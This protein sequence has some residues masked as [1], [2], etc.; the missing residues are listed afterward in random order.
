MNIS[1]GSGSN[2]SPATGM[3]IAIRPLLVRRAFIYG[4]MDKIFSKMFP[5][6]S[7]V[8]ALAAVLAMV[9][10]SPAR[11]QTPRLDAAR[12]AGGFTAPLYVTAPPGDTSRIFVVQQTGQILIINL[13]SRTVNAIPYLD[14]SGEIVYGGEQGLLGMAFDPNYA[15][16]GR[17]YLNYTAPGGSFGAG[18]S[19]IAEF[20]VSSDPDIADPGSEATLLTFDQ[21]QTNHNGGWVGFSSRPGDE[22]N[23]YI[24]TGD[25]GSANDAGEG[26]IEP[27]GNAQN[28]TTLLGKMLRIHIEDAPGTYSIPLDNPFYG[29]DTAKQEIFC[30][31]L[32]N[33]F[34]NSFDRVTGAML[35]G[36]VGQS[37][38]EEID[39]QKVS[40]P[41]GGEN[42]GWRVREGFIQNPAYPNDPPPPDAVDPIFDYPHTTGQ[43]IIGGYIYRGSRIP[44]LSGIYVF[45]D[46]LGPEGGNNTGRIW[47]FRYDGRNVSG[48]RDITSQLFP[49]RVGN[50]P[51]NNPS[52][53]GEDARGE[54]Y[55]CDITNGNIY[56]IIPA[57]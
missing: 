17:F 43:T 25:G 6:S 3:G 19:H 33:P 45:A 41:G 42:Y 47:I 11:A 39:V 35:I 56:K 22:G 26:H 37:S 54:L 55:I 32:R 49:T 52:S 51:L 50:F 28:T 30:F 12:V 44:S 57:R 40:N 48:F 18:V 9:V 20:T 14:I 38:R 21:P 46:Y 16:N 15:T 7:C 53:L 34:R 31:G 24:A 27:G 4:A 13:P 2:F 1:S 29:S 8:R 5:W 10:L 23:L 36:D